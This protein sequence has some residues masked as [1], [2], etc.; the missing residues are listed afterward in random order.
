MADDGAIQLTGSKSITDGGYE[1]HREVP[2]N[3]AVPAH[4]ELQLLRQQ[5]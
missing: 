1:K 5:A 2:T 3:V 4:F